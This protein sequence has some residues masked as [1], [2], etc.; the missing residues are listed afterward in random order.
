MAP[1]AVPLVLVV[2]GL[3]TALGN[4][5][6]G[7]CADHALCRTLITMLLRDGVTALLFVPAL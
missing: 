6:G 4:I 3:G 2:L 5:V 7:F 1:V